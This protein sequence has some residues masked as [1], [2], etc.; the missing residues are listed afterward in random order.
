MTSMD[1]PPLT[2][3]HRNS[4][5]IQID[6]DIRNSLFDFPAFPQVGYVSSLEHIQQKTQQTTGRFSMST[7]GAWANYLP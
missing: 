7:D 1:M 4:T 2:E 5:S 6:I 3:I